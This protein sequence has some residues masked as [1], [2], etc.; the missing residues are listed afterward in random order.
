MLFLE[1][2]LIYPRKG[3]D[4]SMTS[5][6]FISR[7]G[8]RLMLGGKPFRFGGPNIYWLGLDENVG[9]V[10]WPTEFRVLDALD[11]AVQMGAAVVRSHT[12][13]ASQ[14]CPKALSPKR[15]EYNEEAFRRVD[16]AIAEAGRRELRLLVPFVCNW[17]YYHGGRETFAS[18]RGLDDPGLFYTD[19]AVIEDFKSY[20]SVVLNRVNSLTETAYKDDP[21]IMA[22]ELGNELNG[23][24]AE[25]VREIACHIKSEDG[26][27]LISHGKQ[28]ELDRD[29]LGIEELD[30]LDVHYYPA[31]AVKL[32]ADA[33]DTA[34]AGKVYIAG[35]FGWP[36]GDLEGFVSHAEED[37]RVAGTLFWS[38]FGHGDGGGYV[39][40]YDGFSLHYPG[41]GVNE[42]IGRRV[43]RL[44]EHA[45]RMSGRVVPEFPLPEAPVIT[46][47]KEKI[48]FR[49]V[50]GAAM[51][52]LERSSRGADG[53]WQTVFDARE[54]DYDMPWRD[55]LRAHSAKAWY[56]V[57]AHAPDGR[58]G[59]YSPV[60]ESEV[61]TP[62]SG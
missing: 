25:W 21:T 7:E 38:L 33:A 58:A 30:I 27:H 20:I 43:L 13:A 45:F 37:E 39:P 50:A 8:S 23:A 24:P 51:Y 31:D 17:A 46:A 1:I 42:E 14:G 61:F 18:W 47:A 6:E 34:A 59:A 56:R 49:G 19:R 10:D 12:L 35:E 15:G 32:A 28:F 54:A 3:R 9:G 53:P 11:A 55:P 22:W 29:K 2:V 60:Y 57:K 16:F 5:R 52:T 62:E 41:T 40:H 44:R 4:A 26:R 48:M 36:E